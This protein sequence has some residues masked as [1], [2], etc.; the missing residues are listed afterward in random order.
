[1]FDLSLVQ[2]QRIAIFGTG[3][4]GV[5]C[6]YDLQKRG[7]HIDFFLDNNCKIHSF[8]YLP[9]YEL[10][11]DKI[12]N[13][14]IIVATNEQTYAIVSEQL[15][16]M[17]LEEFSDY[18]FF[19]WIKKKVVLLHGNCHL[20]VIEEYLK[21]SGKF[22]KEYAVYPNPRIC[23]N[24]EHRIEDYI[25]SNC[26]VWIHEDIREDNSFGYYLSDQYIRSK[27]KNGAM[28]ITIPHLFGL[29]KAF[30]PQSEYNK[31]NMSIFNSNDLNGMFPHADVVIDRCV[32]EVKTTD[33]IYLFTQSNRALDEEYIYNN[34]N[35]YMNKIRKR[36]KCWDIK[37]YDFIMAHY[38]TEKLFYDFGHP[39]NVVL[40]KIA[41]GILE[42]LNIFDEDIVAQNQLN[43]HETP[44]YPI[45]KKCLEMTWEE[46]EIRK[47]ERCKKVEE[48][49]DFKEY[50]REYIWWCYT[51][52]NQ[53]NG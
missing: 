14:F 6:M 23:N 28:D 24:K 9:V 27:I 2:H 1:M 39:T 30:F 41:I 44:V 13:L 33:E 50:V 32:Q 40:K 26:D 37:I 49:M 22:Q 12:K 31:N 38:K 3:L 7:I 16:E 43:Q 48:T 10:D 47:G 4:F 52:R 46:K 20:D 19:P 18:I 25:L 53:E 5:R 34:F 17:G 51:L 29:G 36:E 35:L 8:C 21:S 45:V 11:S 42:K 15:S